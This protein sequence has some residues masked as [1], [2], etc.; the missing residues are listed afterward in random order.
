MTKAIQRDDLCPDRGIAVRRVRH[1]LGAAF[2]LG[3]ALLAGWLLVEI[4]F[5]VGQ[6][7]LFRWS[8]YIYDHEMGF[9]VRPYAAWG[10]WRANEFGFNDRDYVH[11]KPPGVFR[12]LVLSDSFNWAGGPEGN[13]TA[14][15]RRRLGATIG[16][17]KVEVINAGYPGTHA[18][19]QLIALE[20]YGLAYAPDLVIL[21]VFVGNDILDAQSWRRVIPVG[22]ELTPIDT[23]REP[24]R[25]LFGV[26][27]VWR[28]QLLRFVGA[29]LAVYRL[30]RAARARGDD[31]YATGV[32]LPDEVY[33]ALER[34]RMR[35]ATV[36]PSQELE[37]GEANLFATL[38]A[39][40]KLVSD[41]GASLVVAAYPDE[42][43]VDERLRQAV[44][45]RFGV[46]PRDYDWE[47]P[48]RRLREFCEGRGIEFQDLLPVFRRAQ[49]AG[50][51]LYLRNDSHWNAAGQELAAEALLPVVVGWR[52]EIDKSRITARGSPRRGR[53]GSG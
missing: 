21:G 20:R 35:V 49:A 44:I 3:L 13:Y 12:T 23:R 43:Q 25:T 51:R 45:D 15:L 24:L 17:G 32:S 42:F 31:P 39:M 18:G 9:R 47:R 36:V 22:G 27:F 41:H 16:E 29:R 10:G 33:Q 48:Q 40:R 1:A 52:S 26:P 30:R 5:T 6:G 8:L 2:R 34:E 28:S 46:D 50:Q 38:V 53:G 11:V 14:I 19:E 37:D 4:G 7:G